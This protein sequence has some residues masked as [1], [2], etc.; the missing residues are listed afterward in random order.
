MNTI[1]TLQR[2]NLTESQQTQDFLREYRAGNPN[3][4][5]SG[6]WDA[7]EGRGSI[8]II[9]HVGQGARAGR[10]VINVYGFVYDENNEQLEVYHE[11]MNAYRGVEFSSWRYKNHQLR[12]QYAIREWLDSHKD[13]L[14]ELQWI[15]L[16]LIRGFYNRRQDNFTGD[17]FEYPSPVT[18]HQREV[19]ADLDIYRLCLQTST[20]VLD[21]YGL[22]DP[23]FLDRC[24]AVVNSQG[25]INYVRR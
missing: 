14:T 21:K 23:A 2:F 18:P 25:I 15:H 13:N 6:L 20:D 16:T 17:N 24:E 7:Y 5:A 8:Q 22:L 4:L 11:D 12:A 3:I 1:Q 10:L 9:A 19:S